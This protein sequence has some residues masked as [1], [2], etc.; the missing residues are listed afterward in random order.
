MLID[1]DGVAVTARD[2]NALLGITAVAT[3]DGGLVLSAQD[4]TQPVTVQRPESGEPVRVRI[5]RLDRAIRADGAVHE[6]LS[7]RAGRNV[8]LVWLDDPRRRPV[9]A[10]HGGAASDVMNLADAGE[11][12]EVP[13]EP[14]SMRRFRPNIVVAADP[15]DT[16][17]TDDRLTPGTAAFAEDRW[18]ALRIGEVN[19]RVGELCDRCVMTLIDPQTLVRG[20]EPVRTLARRHSWDG[21]T[22]FG[23]RLIP[24]SSGVVRVG[25]RVVP[26]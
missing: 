9:G 3:A 26:A 5:S 15:D 2:V 18:R 1:D 10:K 19:Y 23:V 6:W 24:E 20:K 7:G 22:W 21:K 13:P 8:E 25:D 4:A 12:G 16:H 11:R 14:L 17:D